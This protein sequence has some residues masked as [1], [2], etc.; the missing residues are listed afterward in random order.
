MLISHSK[1]Q[2]S[3]SKI[4][5]AIELKPDWCKGCY[6]CIDVCPVEGIFKKADLIGSKGFKP[7]LVNPEGCT[8]CQ[9]CE[10]L[11]PDLAITILPFGEEDNYL[12]GV[13]DASDH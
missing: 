2:I 8:N 4:I 10:L 6:L 1:F 9:L 11:C 5:W 12:V 3:N 13:V 7:L